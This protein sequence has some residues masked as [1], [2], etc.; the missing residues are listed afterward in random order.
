MRKLC[1]L[2]I[3]V[4][5][6]LASCG[7]THKIIQDAWWDNWKCITPINGVCTQVSCDDAMDNGFQ[8]GNVFRSLPDKTITLVGQTQADLD[9]C[10]G[11]VK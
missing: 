8:Y 4:V 1:V 3:L 6:L 9:K 5:G 11:G 7:P 2:F 10:E